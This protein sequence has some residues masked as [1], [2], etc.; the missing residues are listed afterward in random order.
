VYFILLNNFNHEHLHSGKYLA[1][2]TS[3]KPETH[4]E[5]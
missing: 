3:L 2:Y 4:S 5:T 1:S